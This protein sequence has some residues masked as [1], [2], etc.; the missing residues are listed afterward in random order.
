MAEGLESTQLP[1]QDSEDNLATTTTAAEE[2]RVNVLT[3]I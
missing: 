3:F 2:V 1:A